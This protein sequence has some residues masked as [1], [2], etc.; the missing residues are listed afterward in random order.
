M[1]TGAQISVLSADLAQKA[2]RI[3]APAQYI[4]HT[5][6]GTTM[7]TVCDLIADCD[8]GGQIIK[9]HRFTVFKD[10]TYPA[11]LGMDLFSALNVKI[12]IGNIECSQSADTINTKNRLTRQSGS[13]PVVGQLRTDGDKLRMDNGVLV[14]LR[15]DGDKEERR[16]FL[17]IG[18]AERVLKVLHDDKG[19]FG[20]AKTKEAVKS[21]YFWFN[22]QK[23]VKHWC[24]SCET[25]LRRKYPTVL[26][27]Q[28][29]GQLPA[30]TR[31][32]RWWHM[33]F[34]G[35]LPKTTRGNKY[36]FALTGPFTKWP[37]AFAVPDQSAQ[38]TAE[39]VYRE[40]VCRYGVPDGLHA[41]QGKNFEANLMRELCKRLDIQR[42]RSSPANPQGNGQAERT[43]R[44]LAE[45][46]A[47]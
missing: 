5:V 22:W 8:I 26:E 25:C 21:R 24:N 19:H 6:D 44:T 34:A 39:V 2:W 11:I 12:H 43:N 29:T 14:L 9:Q 16:A 1:D 10:C 37:E 7:S 33:D 38:T 3:R 15:R 35:P 18:V 41:D 30:P 23:D 45:R 27:R 40:I 20:F 31:P 28:P 13:T 47:I 4:P 46:L 17:P 36:I 42:T 32:F